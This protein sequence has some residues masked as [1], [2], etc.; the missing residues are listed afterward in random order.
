MHTDAS[1]FSSSFPLLTSNVV[2]TCQWWPWPTCRPLWHLVNL[3]PNKSE[4]LWLI[5]EVFIRGTVAS[6]SDVIT[7]VYVASD[8]D[9]IGISCIDVVHYTDATL[10]AGL[11]YR[12]VVYF[13]S[14]T[15]APASTHLCVVFYPLNGCCSSFI[16]TSRYMQHSLC[17]LLR[18]YCQQGRRHGFGRVT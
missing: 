16:A 12:T 4:T 15:R 14:S 5:L 1:L 10:Q 9:Q 13:Y 6:T 7:S 17:G 3:R 8:V 18:H 11:L 2:T